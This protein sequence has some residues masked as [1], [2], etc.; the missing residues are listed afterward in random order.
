MA[1]DSE[2][3][4]LEEHPYTSYINIDISKP[5]NI[6]FTNEPQKEKQKVVGKFKKAEID[7]IFKFDQAN[8]FVRPRHYLLH[9]GITEHSY[10]MD[11]LDTEYLSL[12]QQLKLNINKSDFQSLMKKFD[13]E[14]HYLTRDLIKAHQPDVPCQVCMVFSS[15]LVF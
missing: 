13:L 3:V 9:T 4:L 5:L 12:L 11:I 8:N 2:E 10:D 6:E 15:N 1:G 7:L 14:W